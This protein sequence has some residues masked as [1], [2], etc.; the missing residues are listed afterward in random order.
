MEVL[1]TK[2][3]GVFDYETFDE[4]D[5]FRVERYLPPDA[6]NI[7]VDK[8]A[9]GFRARFKISQTNLDAYL[10]QV[11]RS[12][13]DQSVVERGEMSAMRVVDEE[14]HDL[15]YGDLGWAHL[16]DATEVYGPMARN[17]AGFTVW[18]SPSK[19]IAYQRGSY[20]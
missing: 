14:S 2:R 11:W 3:F 13:G 7:T 18:F 15:Y 8:Y 5:D 17:G 6:T 19:G 20:W 1:D 10:D 4:V 12:Y 9:Q 16:G